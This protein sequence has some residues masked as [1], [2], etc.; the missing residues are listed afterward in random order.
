MHKR[1]IFPIA[2][3]ALVVICT[4][5][6]W[7][8]QNNSSQ[9]PDISFRIIDGRRIDLKTLQG[10]PVL[11][12]FWA[13][14][15]KVCAIEMPQL[16][17]LYDELASQGLEIIGVAMAYDPPNRVLKMSKQKQIPYPIALDIDGNLARAF[18]NV[19]YT[20]TS[21]LIAPDGTIVKHKTG[22]MNINKL[23]EDIITML[24]GQVQK[25]NLQSS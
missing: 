2:I 10:Q 17:A 6:L 15:C 20:P 11:V 8:S 7:L 9:A 18:G 4:T 24:A 12:T 16:M 19:L 14:T 22:E 3:L 23:K 13:T 25:I 21:F 1:T 5:L